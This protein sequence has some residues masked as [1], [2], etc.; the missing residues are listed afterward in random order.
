MLRR[1]VTFL[2]ACAMLQGSAV[3]I[4]LELTMDVR[5]EGDDTVVSG[6]TNLP[7]GT[8]ML[9]SLGKKGGWGTSDGEVWVRAVAMRAKDSPRKVGGWLGMSK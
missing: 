5:Q 2:F 7:D 1:V 9:V 8:R 6:T 4:P 3:A